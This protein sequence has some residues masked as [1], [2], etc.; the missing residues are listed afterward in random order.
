MNKKG[1][2]FFVSPE[3]YDL[4]NKYAHLKQMNKSAFIRYCIEYVIKEI[5]KNEGN[6]LPK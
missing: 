1:I 3:L 5:D 4:I 6:L 2:H